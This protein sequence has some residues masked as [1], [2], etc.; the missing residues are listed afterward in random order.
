MDIELRNFTVCGDERGKL[1]AVEGNKDVP[2]EIKRIYYIYDNNLDLR[3]GFHAHKNLKQALVCVH[4][5]CVIHLDDGKETKEVTL[6][7][8]DLAL[9]IQSSIW[10]EMYNFSPGTVLLVLA[11]EKYQKEDY[12]R[13][14]NEFLTFV[15]EKK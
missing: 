12:I 4:G 1:I 9:F 14:Y 13:D 2:F 3:R 5:S 11:S 6:D 7:S 15:G 10:R 8:P